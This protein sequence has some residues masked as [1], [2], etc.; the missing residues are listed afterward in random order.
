VSDGGGRWQQGV[1]ALA[2]LAKC[3]EMQQWPMAARRPSP[4]AGAGRDEKKAAR[5]IAQ[6]WSSEG[7]RTWL[8]HA[9]R[10]VR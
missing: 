5:R 7:C 3:R 1:T 4:G 10:V 6:T 9:I 8:Q 2:D